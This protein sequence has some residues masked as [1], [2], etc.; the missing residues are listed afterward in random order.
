MTKQ[1]TSHCTNGKGESCFL[2]NSNKQVNLINVNMSTAYAEREQVNTVSPS[3]YLL[4]H[5]HN[6]SYDRL[7][8][9]RSITNTHTVH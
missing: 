9:L 7:L 3:N 8:N 2:L 1:L 6:I 4:F 5:E